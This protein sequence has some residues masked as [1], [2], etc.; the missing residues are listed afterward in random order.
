[1]NEM[2]PAQQPTPAP[3]PPSLAVWRHMAGRDVHEA[4]RSSTPLE[5]LFD[6]TTVV[7]VAA[8]ATRLHHGLVEGHLREAGLEFFQSF[9]SIWWPWMSYSWFASAYD[10]DDVPF[11]F[12]TLV[13]MIGVLF[14]AAGITEAAGDGLAG[15]IGFFLMRAALVAQWWRASIEHPEGRATCRRYAIGIGLLQVLWLARMAAAPT[16]WLFPLFLLLAALELAIPVWA[17]R[18]GDTPWHAHHVTERY[19][20]LTIILLGECMVAAANAMSGVLAV[21]GWSIDLMA[22]SV[23]I[24]GL[25]LGLWWAYFLVPF[26]QVL[27]F[28]RERGFLWGYGHAL[29]FGTLAVL[30]GVLEVA[31]DALKTASGA[32]DHGAAPEAATPLLAMS[33][34]SLTVAAFFAALWWLGSSTTRR[35]SRS[36][37]FLLPVPVLGAL[38]VFLV[39]RGMPLPWGFVLLA[40][41]PALTVGLVTRARRMNPENFAVR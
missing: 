7:A 9:F 40:L 23:G 8:A 27:H 3:L 11:R 19:G 10:T 32:E 28:R 39:H 35:A 29:V 25:I 31:V 14:I 12:A 6:L 30:G 2:N 20:L 13:Q 4:H 33:L 1:M 21:E 37:A 5:A 22:V 26:A 38:A 24:V 41:G 17:A 15:T 18:A 16:D 34:S 36:P